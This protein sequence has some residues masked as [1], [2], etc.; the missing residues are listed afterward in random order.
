MTLALLLLLELS[1][2]AS[3]GHDERT[4]HVE[5]LLH[6]KSTG[7]YQ[8]VKVL[9]TKASS[10]D[11]LFDYAKPFA[12]LRVGY[13]Y[14]DS[15]FGVDNDALAYGGQ[16]GFKTAQMNGFSALL[17]A[18]TSQN[19]NLNVWTH[20]T[21]NNSFFDKDTQGFTYLAEANLDYENELLRVKVG[22]IRID[23][24]FADSDDIR[25]APNT[26]EG[27]WSHFSVNDMIKIQTF[28]LSR[29][30]GFDSRQEDSNG[31]IINGQDEFKKFTK[32]SKGLGSVSMSYVTGNNEYSAWYYYID[33]YAQIAYTEAIGSSHIS[34]YIHIDW[35][36]QLSYFDEL[37]NSKIEGSVSGLLSVV[38]YKNIFGSVA[39]NY[40]NVDT[41]NMITDGFAGGPNFTSLDEMGVATASQLYPGNDI[42]AYRLGV[43]Y[44]LS[45]LKKGALVIELIHGHF[46]VGNISK[47]IDEDDVVISYTF[48]D[49]W[50]VEG[51]FAFFDNH[52]NDSFNR[53]V[54]RLDYSF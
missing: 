35:G 42:L 6:S 21:I 43:G 37:E 26:F 3:S 28:Y 31:N 14:N 51:V 15:S 10:F 9:P 1:D 46:D 52:A 54:V 19:A 40:A 20:S 49:R 4:T 33:K 50:Y 32:D 18:Y 34:D 7:R 23:T 2:V 41:G 22:R 24:P 13:I 44:E 38:H 17:S 5:G 25:M 12:V 16:F 39:L 27:I 29:W 45:T 30:A 47:V 11:E 48:L 8:M 36:V 53:G